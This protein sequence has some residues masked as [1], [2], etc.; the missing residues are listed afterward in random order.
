MIKTLKYILLVALVI[1]CKNNNIEKPKKPDNLISK[2]KMVTIIYDISLI[3]SVKGVNKKVIENQGISPEDYIYKRHDIDSL[4][5]A[6]SNEYYAYNL[7]TYEVIY[8]SVKT[9]LEN[10]KKKFQEIIEVEKKIKD[11]INK[12]TRR[13][14]DSLKKIG[15]LIPN[16]KNRNRDS[17]FP[18]PIKKID[19]SR[20]LTRQ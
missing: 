13:E 5:F 11:S 19:T 17:I 10:D 8:N 18:R 16:K 20:I 2:D 12:K 6:L 7:K 3:N 9:K 1:S 14:F 15:K 4:Q